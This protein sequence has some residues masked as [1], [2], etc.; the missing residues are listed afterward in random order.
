[1]DP[2]LCSGT[3]AM[4]KPTT[5]PRSSWL[6]WPRRIFFTL[7]ILLL[8]LA[9]ALWFAIRASLPQLDGS[10]ALPG[11]AAPLQIERDALGTAVL[12]GSNR[13]DLARGLGFV[14]GQERFFE[15]DLT[16]RS[17][18]GELSALFGAVAIERDKQRR[19]HRLRARLAARLPQ[20]PAADQA[21][22]QAYAEGVNAGLAQLQLRPWQYLLLSTEPQAWNAVDSLLVVSEMYFMLQGNSF[23]AGFERALLRERAGDALFDWLN[24]RGGSWDAA[25]DGSQLPPAPLP[26]LQQLDL[27]GKPPVKS[28]A[29]SVGMEPEPV[30]GSNNWAVAG[31]RSDHGGAILA[32]D[33]HLGLSVPSIWLRAQLQLGTGPQALRAAGL[34]LPGLPALVVGSNGH[35]AWG[36][37]NAYGQWFDWIE[38]PADAKLSTIKESIAVKGG[39]TETLEVQELDGAPL[40]MQEGQRRF[41]LR[42]IAHDGEAYNLALDGMLQARTV[43]EALSVAQHSGMPH[44]NLL[45]AD[46]QGQIGWTIAGRLWSQPGLAQS[47]AR[48]VAPGAAKHEWLKPEAAPHITTPESGQLWTANH[49]PLGGELAELLGDG[50][51]DLGARAQQ[52]RDRLSAQARHDEASL[53]AIHLD[54]EA[55]FM[56]SWAKRLLPLAQRSPAHAETATLIEQWN[57]RAEADQVGYRLLRATR[58]RILDTLWNAWTAPLLGERQQ[59]AKR[60]IKWRAQ[61]EYSAVQALEQRPA[62]LL[63]ADYKDW[64]ALLLAQLDAAVAE[65]RQD[66]RQPLARATWG[67]Q[68]ASRIQHVLSKAIPPLAALLDMPSLPQGGDSNL[69]HVAGP[70][71]GQ[72]QRLVVAPGR[73]AQATLSMPGGQ[74]GHPMSPFYGAGHADWVAGRATP[75][76]AG[77]AEHRLSAAP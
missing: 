41:A 6:R 20:L 58:L 42:W 13:V 65:L 56:Q 31:S 14:H 44:Q 15:M 21:V 50:G 36:F 67:Q 37:T 19:A 8:A 47:Y 55:R 68:N 16:R 46:S 76:L 4:T 62:H 3:R 27:R 25:L 23:E 33:M 39:A 53:G 75:L 34:S 35:I 74:S 49:R 48:F 18:A 60:R 77:P 29:A 1:M 69:P 5:T 9:A 57:G 28:V 22:L 24:P 52:I 59:D 32:D 7:L 26:T 64:D 66:G 2:I 40:L 73:E 10:I 51:F 63:P 61:F 12:Q 72:S 54:N 70:T 11:L 38:V 71:F 43:A 17:A 30:L 45:A